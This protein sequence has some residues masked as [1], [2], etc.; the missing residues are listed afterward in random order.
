MKHRK[1]IHKVP[2]CKD[3]LKKSCEF[4]SDDCYFTHTNGAQTNTAQ[5]KTQGFILA[6]PP[7]QGFWETPANLAPPV[8]GKGPT[9]SELIQIKNM[10]LQL[11]QMVNKFQ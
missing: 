9:Q 7:A 5:E 3:F 4:S 11:N 10:L 1:A 8:Q 6:P 2:I